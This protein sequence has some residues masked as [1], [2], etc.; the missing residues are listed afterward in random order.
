M[1]NDWREKW[2]KPW[3]KK[4]FLEENGKNK[5]KYNIDVTENTWFESKEKEFCIYFC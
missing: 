3:K 5:Y 1:K 4:G 2:K